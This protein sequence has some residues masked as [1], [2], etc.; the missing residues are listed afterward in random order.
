MLKESAQSNYPELRI[1]S[2]CHVLA[3]V[4]IRSIIATL[5]PSWNFSLA[6]N[7]A[8]LSLQDG[9]RSGYIIA[10]DRRPSGRP[11]K[12]QMDFEICIYQ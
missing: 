8:S 9:P 2:R 1:F 4:W 12:S 6:E 11:S 10:I 7:L 5:G 3:L